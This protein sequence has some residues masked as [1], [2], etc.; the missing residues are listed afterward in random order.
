ADRANGVPATY[1][2]S[3]SIVEKVGQEAIDEA[4]EQ[5][6][7][8]RERERVQAAAADAAAVQAWVEIEAVIGDSVPLSKLG[9]WSTTHLDRSTRFTIDAVTLGEIIHLAQQKALASHV[10]DVSLMD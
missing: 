3:R 1:L 6:R 8:R 2:V 10:D 7:M 4:A 9:L 5:E